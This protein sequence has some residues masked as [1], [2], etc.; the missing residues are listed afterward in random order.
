MTSKSELIR[1]L[2][3]ELD[4]IESG[5]YESPAGHP[6]LKRPLFDRSVSMACINHWEVPGHEKDC[7]EDCVLLDSVPLANRGEKMPCH[8][9]PLND[10]GDTVNTLEAKAGRERTQ[11]EVKRW[12]RRKIAQLKR[13]SSSDNE[14]EV[15]Y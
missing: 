4:L 15:R 7:H 8:H 6:E 5:G 3:A 14:K 2:E 12:L 9:I 13:E 1:L 11:E 10:K